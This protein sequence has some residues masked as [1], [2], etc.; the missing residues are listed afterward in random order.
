MLPHDEEHAG[1]DQGVLDDE[2]VQVGR[3]V[4]HD[5]AHDLDA[6]AAAVHDVLLREALLS[7]RE[8]RR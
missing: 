3:R 5:A 2:G 1:G 7:W 6:A 4:G 8:G